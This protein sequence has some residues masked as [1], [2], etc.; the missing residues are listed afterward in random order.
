LLLEEAAARPFS[1]KL[2]TLD[3]QPAS[4][5]DQEAAKQF[6]R[7]GFLPLRSKERFLRFEGR[8]IF[9][10]S[11]ATKFLLLV[12]NASMHGSIAARSSMYEVS[13]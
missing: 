12:L 7:V 1:G 6:A 10:T 11:T 5:T 9:S 8:L 4:M 3:R 13:Y 2:A